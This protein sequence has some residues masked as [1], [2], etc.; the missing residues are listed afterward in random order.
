MNTGPPQTV[1]EHRTYSIY[2][3]R[4]I[5]WTV[6]YDATKEQVSDGSESSPEEDTPEETQAQFGF[7]DQSAASSD[8]DDS[9]DEDDEDQSERRVEKDD[10]APLKFDHRDR[11]LLSY[12]G[13]HQPFSRLRVRR[14]DQEWPSKLLTDTCS[15]RDTSREPRHGG[16]IGEL[17]LLIALMAFAIPAN[18]LVTKLCEAMGRTWRAPRC[19]REAGC[20]LRAFDDIPANTYLMVRRG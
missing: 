10:W 11:D 7:Q 5:F 4:A 17:P 9:D 12:A 2:H 13:R 16:L 8:V 6:D 19:P 3:D 15:A 1:E 14:P 20:K 18:E